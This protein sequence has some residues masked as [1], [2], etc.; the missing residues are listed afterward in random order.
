MIEFKTRMSGK[1]IQFY[2]EGENFYYNHS[3]YF[4]RPLFFIN[5]QK[6]ASSSIGEFLKNSKIV[7]QKNDF[8]FTVVRDPLERFK[9]TMG[10]L[11]SFLKEQD[12]YFIG[13]CLRKFPNQASNEI[14]GHICHFVPQHLHLR[15]FED[16]YDVNYFHIE[17]L[18]SL[19]LELKK[20]TSNQIPIYKSNQTRYSQTNQEKIDNWIYENK[21]FVDDFLGPDI[22]WLGKITVR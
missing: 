18:A 8:W 6:N 7:K 9:S 21:N 4:H 14:F 3:F 19:H 1:K 12:L 22:E 5:I 20:F 16:R 17:N 13:N 10:Y 11:M 15:W 2:L